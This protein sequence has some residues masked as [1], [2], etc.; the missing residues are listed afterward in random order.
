MD[1]K[2]KKGEH[3]I[4]IGITGTLGAG[5]GTIVDYLVRNRG[6]AHFSVRSFLLAEIRKRGMPENRDSMFNLANELRAAYGPSYVIDKLFEKALEKGKNCVIESIRLPGEIESLRQKGRF[7]LLAVDAAPATRYKRIVERQSET[8]AVSYETFLENETREMI[9][10]DPS[11]QNI[12]TCIR[13]S[14][15]LITNDGSFDDLVQKTEEVLSA[16]C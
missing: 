1:R 2:P 12:K 15:Y 14:D 9:N 3:M 11:K 10:S 13:M 5:K 8:D 4:I 16:I 7:V 6:F